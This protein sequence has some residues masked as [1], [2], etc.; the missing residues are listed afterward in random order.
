MQKFSISFT[1]GKASELHGAN[2]DH[3]NRDYIAPNVDI[4]RTHQNI[5][6]VRYDVEDAYTQLF[7][8][9]LAE[10]NAKQKQKCRRIDDYYAHIRDGKREEAF[11]EIVVQ[12]GDSKTAP[13]ESERGNM[14]QTMLDEYVRNF[15]QRNPNLH[16]FNAV[17]HLD[18]ASPHLHLNVIPFYTKPRQRGLRV[19]VSM[20]QALIEQGF[21]PNGKRQNQL[22]AWE[23]S[24]RAFM[25]EILH[26]H[27]FERE[28]KQADYAHLSVE[29]Y[30][31]QQ[32][33]K[34]MMEHLRR[35]HHITDQ[36]LLQ[37]QVR[38]LENKAALLEQEC[39]KL[40]ERR[41]S[42]FKAFAYRDPEQLSFVTAK[43][44]AERI[45]YCET[46]YGF[47]AQ[48]CDTDA[49]RKIERLYQPVKRSYRAVLRDDVDYLLMQSLSL[50]ELLKRLQ[51]RGYEIKQGKYLAVRPRSGE[52]FIRLCSLGEDYSEQSL[53]NRLRR[54]QD[55][56]SKVDQQIESEN[57]RNSPHWMV[58]RTIR[59]YTISFRKGVMPLRRKQA[60]RPLSWTNDAELDKL[61]RLNRMLNEGL[62]HE[63]MRSTFEEQIEEVDRLRD[64]VLF[65]QRDLRAF[66]ALEEQIQIVFEGAL[67]SRFTPQEA[68][69]TLAKHPNITRDNYRNIGKLLAS[70]RE[71]LKEAEAALESGE[72]RLKETADLVSLMEK[73]MAGTYVQSLVTAE[74]HRR[75]SAYLPNGLRDA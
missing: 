71:T 30:K 5:T 26:R 8:A 70:E 67:S 52:Q 60:E 27:G 18:E 12:F 6:Y 9:A 62:T 69:Q 4:T 65:S 61:L 51:K 11:Y 47:A 73:V 55:F 36:T 3:N 64:A 68:Q 46:D 63:K 13:C 54:K 32:D 2:L 21:S 44:D 48:A 24:E 25:E 38:A 43:L 37:Q 28:D 41:S 49:I 53:R 23:N 50:E 7:G 40:E 1:L 59:F 35:V 34:E 16:L 42:P 19:G 20:K 57:D 15:R 56:E 39:Q 31:L 29:D 33:R 75:L 72:Q 74:Q 45:R 58:L 14:A 66:E 10:Y 22:V 17:L